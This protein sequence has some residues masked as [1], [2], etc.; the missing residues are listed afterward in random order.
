MMLI[1]PRFAARKSM[2]IAL[3]SVLLA[4]GTTTALGLLLGGPYCELAGVAVVAV[5][6]FY[7]ARRR[8]F[9][10]L[11]A[12]CSSL[13]FE[14]CCHLL[15]EVLLS[16]LKPPG[17]IWIRA[18]VFAAGIMVVWFLLRPRL[19]EMARG[20]EWGWGR[21][22]LVPL[23]M[24]LSMLM[25]LSDRDTAM[26]E[27]MHLAGATAV[28][29]TAIVLYGVL[30]F[31]FLQLERQ[32]EMQRENMLLQTQVS[33]MENQL[34]VLQDQQRERIIYH[35]LRHY[36][37]VI[38][39]CMQRGEREEALENLE[40]LCS[41]V[42]TLE[43]REQARIYCKSLTLNAALSHYI[44]LAE[45]MGISVTTSL[46]FPDE[47]AVDKLELSVVFANAIENAIN[48]C[49]RMPAG[50]ERKISLVSYPYRRR[51]YI[52]ISNTCAE[53]VSFD[54]KSGRPLTDRDGHGTGSLSIAAFAQKYGALLRYE[55]S[56]GWFSLRL[57]L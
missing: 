48:A 26:G 28:L 24:A 20:V 38:S 50:A 4:V 41:V 45:Q 25:L 56:D 57:L 40:T 1:D 39:A 16:L 42:N 55:N 18:A 15:S 9:R 8:D 35:D 46:D 5:A 19:L 13:L 21:L 2:G 12:V 11:F 52:E 53:Q 49:L 32:S 27:P 51:Q 30:T 6:A 34:G 54:R 36:A 44:Q 7:L 29:V 31:L 3:V 14:V 17:A 22:C 47:F 43:E 23:L 37:Q 10:T 33:A